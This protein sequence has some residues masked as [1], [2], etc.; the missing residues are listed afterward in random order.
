MTADIK[1]SFI[2]KNSIIFNVA[3][4]M[5][6]TFFNTDGTGMSTVK[7]KQLKLFIFPSAKLH[8]IVFCRGL[9]YG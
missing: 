2:D 6:T 7:L 3:G 8:V 4:T 5:M 1:G 9:S